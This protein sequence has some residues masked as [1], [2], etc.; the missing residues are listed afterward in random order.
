MQIRSLAR[1]LLCA[2]A[3]SPLH[4]HAQVTQKPDGQWRSLFTAGA[5]IATG[6]TDAKSASLGADVI[7]LTTTDKWA[8]TG[9]A[10]YARSAGATTANHVGGSA[11]YSSDFTPQWF[12][13]GE[14]D[15]L[16]DLPSD[17]SLRTTLGS[18]IGYHVVK[19]PDQSFD[20]SAGLAYTMDR[21]RHEQVI[22]DETRRRYDH[23]ELLFAEESNNKLSDTTTF[24]QKLTVYPNLRD[25]GDVRTVFDAGLS[26]AMTRQLALTAT[27]SHRYDSRPGEGL[28]RNDTLFVTGVSLRFD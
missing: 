3:A 13:F 19:K 25:T 11:L 18:G 24:K 28:G 21:Y 5:S 26:V 4:A 23:A 2:V 8:L 9:A 22:Q 12:G 14:L 27:L 7:K 20:L 1:A 16:H 6:N 15:L 10:Q 17:L